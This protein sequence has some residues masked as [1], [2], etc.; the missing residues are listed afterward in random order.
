MQ[1][2]DIQNYKAF[3]SAFEAHDY[4]YQFSL[5]AIVV[6]VFAVIIA[7]AININAFVII[8]AT[9]VGIMALS[10]I[11]LLI[12]KKEREI[13]LFSSVNGLIGSLAI[14][15][16]MVNAFHNDKTLFV[17]VIILMIG[18]YA[19]SMLSSGILVR[20][21]IKK[22]YYGNAQ[23]NAGDLLMPPGIALLIGAIGCV[24]GRVIAN[25]PIDFANIIFL[26]MIVM[27]SVLFG[28]KAT[29][30]LLRH[31]VVCKYNLEDAIRIRSDYEQR[32]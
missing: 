30:L 14:C 11:V 23:K 31:I 8:V 3:V 20:I 13:F 25:A 12:R 15:M 28:F 27:M 4:N 26:L 18:C 2:K 19:I 9:I 1:E 32:L 6:S 22:N 10:S 24:A 5:A 16:I 7:L 21:R 17:L 29:E